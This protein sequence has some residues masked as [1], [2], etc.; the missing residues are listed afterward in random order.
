MGT[1]GPMAL[2]IPVDWR[3][4]IDAFTQWLAAAGKSAETL[5]LRRVHLERLARDLRPLGPFDVTT[6][7]LLGWMQAQNWAIETRRANRGTLRTFY[8]W[9]AQGGLMDH[10]PADAL[11]VVRPAPPRPRPATEIQLG[12][13]LASAGARERLMVRLAAEVGLRRAEVA[14]LHSRDLAETPCG[15]E[16]T[17]HG[18]GGR[19][20]VLP[21]PDGLASQ[22]RALEPGWVFPSPNGGHLTP[23]YVAKKVS[24]LLPPGVT[25][26]ALRHR[27][28]T[29]VYNLDRDVF[30]VQELLG[31][32]SPVT[33]RRYVKVADGTLR[34]SVQRLADMSSARWAGR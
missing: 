31:H 22:L 13:A 33:T 19:T 27:F 25:M 34:S 15:W 30:A 18:K 7:D 21:L 32:S 9:A 4:P 23:A 16:I 14:G 5:R 10:N 29:E 12:E 11:P 2:P 6:L 20:R 8:K 17:V 26:H 3:G 1:T 24:D 28:A